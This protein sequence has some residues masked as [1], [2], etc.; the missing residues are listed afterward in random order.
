MKQSYEHQDYLIIGFGIT[1]CMVAHE[2][3]KRGRSFTVVDA[4]E[5]AASYAAG[6]LINPVTGLRFVKS[7]RV[8]E[9]LP[10]AKS[11]YLDLEHRWNLSLWH[12]LQVMRVFRDKKEAERWRWRC[13]RED[14]R[15]YVANE[16]QG[17]N[18]YA[19]VKPDFGGILIDQA[20]WINI[21]LLLEKTRSLLLAQ[22]AYIKASVAPDELKI[23]DDGVL[24]KNFIFKKVI[25]CT[26]Y[27]RQWPWFDWLPWK[28]AKGETLTLR[29]KDWPHEWH[30]T[31]LNCGIFMLPILETESASEKLVRVGATYEWHDL[32][33]QPTISGKNSLLE[34]IDRLIDLDYEVIDHRA[35]IRPIIK[36]TRP[37]VG[38]HPD[39]LCK[40]FFLLNGMGSKGALWAPY[41]TKLLINHIENGVSID[42]EVDVQRNL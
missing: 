14:M 41:C 27:G 28:P 4:G 36:D 22:G 13:Q 5:N 25:F 12:S 37:V 18:G 9:L 2:L 17:D 15:D 32:N 26:G 21:P 20:A 6:W 3:S 33:T 39:P 42:S 19:A 1:G 35:G 30:H 34:Q 7:W 16:W 29:V 38:Q 11:T 40:N 31:V 23:M 8:Q 24:Y 10:V